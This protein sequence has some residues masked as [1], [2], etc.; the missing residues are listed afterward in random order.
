VQK[1]RLI[2]GGTGA[3]YLKKQMIMK[4]KENRYVVIISTF[5]DESTEDVTTRQGVSRNHLLS[6]TTTKTWLGGINRND[7]QLQS[8]K[9]D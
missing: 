2:K 9:W 7:G 5:H 6:L 8:Y 4:W 1:A 3:A